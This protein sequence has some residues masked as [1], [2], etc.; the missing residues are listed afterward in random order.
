MYDPIWHT[1]RGDTLISF[2]TNL[3]GFELC[4]ESVPPHKPRLGWNIKESQFKRSHVNMAL[5]RPPHIKYSLGVKKD[6]V[7]KPIK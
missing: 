2:Y 3:N 7:G 1:P 5:I 4:P 6:G